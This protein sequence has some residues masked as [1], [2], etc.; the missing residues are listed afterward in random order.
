MSELCERLDREYGVKIGG[1]YSRPGDKNMNY[2][3]AATNMGVDDDGIERTL[4]GIEC[5]LA[6]R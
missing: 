5:I 2:I 3:R 6:G 4:E 1:G